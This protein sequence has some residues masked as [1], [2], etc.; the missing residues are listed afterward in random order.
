MS[1]RTISEVERSLDASRRELESAV[2][3]LRTGLA[4]V[5]DVKAFRDQYVGM[6]RQRVE[7][8]QGEIQTGVKS[9]VVVLAA[10]GLV[11]GF[12]VGGGVSGL[13]GLP[14]KLIVVVLRVPIG[15]VRG[16]LR[17]PVKLVRTTLRRPSSR[18]RLEAAMRQNRS[19]RQVGRA[20][21]VLAAADGQMRGGLGRG[22]GGL[23]RSKVVRLVVLGGAG[24]GVLMATTDEDT[25]ANLQKEALALFAKGR[26]ELAGVID[27]VR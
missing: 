25:R 24:A 23:L 27:Q 15:V 17:V 14:I 13:L 21:A 26:D 11:I 1:P 3:D 10:G 2:A 4:R 22:G 8:V 6:A 19:S 16:V 7:L 9:E 12:V 18:T 5:T 20:L